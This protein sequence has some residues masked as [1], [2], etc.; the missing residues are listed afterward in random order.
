[1][2]KGTLSDK[3]TQLLSPLNALDIPVSTV[4]IY[5]PHLQTTILE[6]RTI[7]FKL[8]I[9]A[10][11]DCCILRGAYLRPIIQIPQIPPG[12]L[13]VLRYDWKDGSEKTFTIVGAR[14]CGVHFVGE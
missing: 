5:K 9:K 8:Q 4:A 13:I 14:M 3:A 11:C 10:S 2:A 12:P 1:M 6:C 7:L